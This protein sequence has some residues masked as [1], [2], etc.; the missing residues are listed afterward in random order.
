MCGFLWFDIMWHV[1]IT[2]CMLCSY[3][4]L[5][6]LYPLFYNLVINR[7]FFVH[8][9][10]AHWI[11]YV[12]YIIICKP[13]RWH[14]HT[15]PRSASKILRPVSLATKNHAKI[16]WI[17]FITPYDWFDLHQVGAMWL[18]DSFCA[19]KISVCNKVA[20]EGIIWLYH[21]KSWSASRVE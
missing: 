9:T 14:V 3:Y 6:P 16:T 4:H 8:V 5:K 20:I 2:L 11:F 21:H 15:N 12:V 19:K 1:E 18:P 7:T 17:P 13:E 10:P